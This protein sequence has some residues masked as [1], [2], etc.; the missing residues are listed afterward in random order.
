[1]EFATGALGTLLANLGKLLQDEYNLQKGVK[2]DIEFIMRDLESMHAALR[3]VGE[4]PQEQLKKAV[5]IWARDVRELSYDME[6]IVDS[7]LVRVQGSEPP[8]KRSTKRIKRMASF[9]TKA[10]TYH[11]ICQEIKVIKERVKEVAER[12]DRSGNTKEFAFEF[13]RNFLLLATLSWF[14]LLSE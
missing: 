8:S 2:K 6:D 12:R 3:E 7:F 14:F 10:T 1:M 5:K 4:V 9:V 11:D 13:H